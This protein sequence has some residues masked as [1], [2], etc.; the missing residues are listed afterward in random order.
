MWVTRLV[1]SS[2]LVPILE[3]CSSRS[4]WVGVGLSVVSSSGGVLSFLSPNSLSLVV[5]LDVSMVRDLIMSRIT[6]VVHPWMTAITSIDQMTSRLSGCDIK[7]AAMS[8]M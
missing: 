7:V 6:E 2:K 5:D 4:D 3:I 1:R 8:V